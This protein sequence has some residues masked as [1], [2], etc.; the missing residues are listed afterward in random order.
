VAKLSEDDRG[1]V[2]LFD[3]PCWVE[4]MVTTPDEVAKDSRCSMLNVRLSPSALPVVV[5]KASRP[6]NGSNASKRKK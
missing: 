1:P 3:D 6:R 2:V 4:Y 5:A